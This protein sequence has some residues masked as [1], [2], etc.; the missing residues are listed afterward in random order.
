MVAAGRGPRPAPPASSPVF[1]LRL[2]RHRG[3]KLLL[4]LQDSLILNVLHVGPRGEQR[5]LTRG[6]RARRLWGRRPLPSPD[7]PPPGRS[8]PSCL[9]RY[10]GRL[11]LSSCIRL[12]K[13]RRKNPILCAELDVC[14][15]LDRPNDRT[16][17]ARR[18][19]AEWA[20]KIGPASRSPGLGE[21]SSM[22][23]E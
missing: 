5:R 17:D 19:R 7:P 18:R 14:P 8:P 22:R 10:H 2:E 12:L 6:R 15:P 23:N 20:G 21:F 11:S 13:E 4:R 16:T 1:E 3:E 9:P